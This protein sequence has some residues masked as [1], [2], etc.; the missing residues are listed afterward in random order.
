MSDCREIVGFANKTHVCDHS[1]SLDPD[2]DDRT[3]NVYAGLQ[4]FVT[5]QMTA[6]ERE[7]F[8]ANTI[9]SMARRAQSLKMHR[10]PRGLEF[11]LQ[12]QSES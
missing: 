3:E 7:H 2:D 12:Q 8:T 1:V 11:S 5:T 4:T 9:K 6:F 10:P